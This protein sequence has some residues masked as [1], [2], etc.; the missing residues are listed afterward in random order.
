MA[1]IVS[2]E[3]RSRMMVGIR[4]KGTQP[5]L[6]LRSA[7]HRRGYRFRLHTKSLPGVPD[8]VL[9]KYKAVIF[10]HGCFWH[11]HGCHLFK[12]P[13]SRQSFWREKIGANK[14]RDEATMLSL[15]EAGW[16][17][18]V[19]WECALKGKHRL[20]LAE[21]IEKCEDWLRSEDRTLEISGREARPPL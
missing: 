19:V 4:G 15:L 13:S 18:A 10:A 9:R 12:W 16:R 21:V 7:L 20:Q 2:P 14:L 17:V 6:T 5:E 1:D 3:R 11:A 8:L